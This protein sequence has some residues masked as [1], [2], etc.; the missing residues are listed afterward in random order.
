MR[1]R[2]V[3]T[4]AAVV[5]LAAAT[6]G[7]TL[8]P[9][10]HTKAVADA[11]CSAETLRGAYALYGTGN[12]S[13]VPLAVMGRFMFDGAGHTT[14]TMVESYGGVID[15]GVLEGTYSLDPGCR[16]S[17]TATMKHYVRRTGHAG[18][19]HE[20][21]HEI[22]AADIVVASGGQKFFWVLVDT[23]PQATPPGV[24]ATDDPITASGWADKM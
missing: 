19:A 22:H 24:P 10:N 15:D 4:S 23:Y 11:G 6:V 12:A 17:I 21:R 18:Q 8:G 1:A 14:V 16:G 7:F 3:L 20:Y 13:G 9:G 5:G 2:D